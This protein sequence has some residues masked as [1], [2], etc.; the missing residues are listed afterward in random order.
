MN[1]KIKAQST[2]EG[3]WGEAAGVKGSATRNDKLKNT[4][5][6]VI[7]YNGPLPVLYVQQKLCIAIMTPFTEVQYM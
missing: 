7:A 3:L 4:R 1:A 5:E 6:S 2:I